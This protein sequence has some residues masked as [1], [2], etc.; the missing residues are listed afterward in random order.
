MWISEIKIKNFRPFYG[1]N[2]PFIVELN[3]STKDKFT[4]IEAKSD[5]G[6]TTFLSALAWCFYGI[7]TSKAHN[8]SLGPFCIARRH[9]MKDKEIEDMFVE[10][11]LNDSKNDD[12]VYVIKRSE[13]Y[14]KI[15]KDIHSMKESTL[16]ITEWEDNNS[17]I[18]PDYSLNNVING[19]LPKDIHLFFMFEGEKLEK[20]F[21]FNNNDNIKQ[22]IERT[23]QIQQIKTSIKHL[24]QVRD[25][26]WTSDEDSVDSEIEGIQHEI[27][28]ED[29]YILRNEEKVS[30]SKKEIGEAE[31]KFKD[32]EK[33]L[34]EFNI[35]YIN[36]L[37]LQEKELRLQVEEL[38]GNIK[39]TKKGLKERILSKAP[40]AICHSILIK[41][42]DRLNEEKEKD[43]LEPNIENRYLKELIRQK[44]CVCGRTLNPKTKADCS[45]IKLINEKL[46]Q[47]D[48]SE[49]REIILDGRYRLEDIKEKIIPEFI[50]Y[51]D[52]MNN[53]IKKMEENIAT[54]QKRLEDIDKK[55]KGTDK[56]TITDKQEEKN[57]LNTA[58]KEQTKSVA[59]LESAINQKKVTISQLRQKLDKLGK[60]KKGTEKKKRIADFL[61]RSI[62]VLEKMQLD[63]LNE[64]R[65]KVQEKTWEYFSTLHW[66]KLK[67]RSFEI[68][69]D[70]DLR[71][72]DAKSTNWMHNLASG[73]KQ[74]L[75]LSFIAALSEISGFRFPVFI[76]TP[77]AN[78]D[79]EQRENVAKMLPEYLKGNQVIML[80][81][82]QEYTPN[83]RSLMK[84][85]IAQEMRFTRIQNVTE[86]KK[87]N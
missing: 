41:L 50:N 7:E 37:S 1:L 32:I 30:K 23:S 35:P 43:K 69:E 5:V 18:I 45:C 77:F 85:R 68:N 10:I 22:A 11:T 39:N 2:K 79:N 46:K 31:S 60:T 20:H 75:L 44:K 55:L 81:K 9:E 19:I 70:Y 78:I 4:I 25:N 73:P 16:E 67:Y 71:L 33:F 65:D 14:Q 62:K 42:L 21:S 76:D 66:D 57:I 51:S 72:N 36:E 3:K 63:I 15:G 47:N 38:E 40:L 74:L 13:L 61:D 49:M 52:D 12:P 34:E 56:K 59:R 82:D 53:N 27:K 29:D 83:I 24:M 26:V 28:Q 6:K 87:W 84:K 86:V 48:I 54:K 8:Q 17:R 64:V 58:I 80:M